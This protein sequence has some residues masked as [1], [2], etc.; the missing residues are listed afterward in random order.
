MP[1]GAG[2][3]ESYY[4]KA[5]HPD[6]GLG[7]W[8]RYTVH[9]RPGG[10]PKAF[11]WFTLFDAERGVSAAKVEG[12]EPRVDGGERYIGIGESHLGHGRIVGSAPSEPVP[13]SWDISFDSPEPPVWHLPHPWMYSAPFPR[14]KVLSPHPAVALHGSARVG[15]RIIDLDG[16]QGTIGHNWGAEHAHRA[17]WIHA[18]GFEGRERSWLDLAIGRIR[19]ASLTTPWIANGVLCLDGRRHRLGGFR[20]LRATHIDETPELCRF[21]LAGGDLSIEGSVGADRRDFVGWI[22]AQPDGSQRQ[23]VNCSIADM[24]L[25]VL[26]RHAEPLVIECRGAAAYELQMQERY[27]PIPVQPFPDG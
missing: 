22:Y 16:W 17:I 1:E 3:Y 14:T 6:G 9:K 5:T 19:L 25:T 2:H 23:T 10:R 11:L 15:D 8:I 27:G 18:A 12:P 13:A 24:R 7:I 26:R 20:R 21:A 4:L